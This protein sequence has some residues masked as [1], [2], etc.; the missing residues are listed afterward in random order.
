MYN[1]QIE[2]HNNHLNLIKMSLT[3]VWNNQQSLYTI[4]HQHK[5]YHTC[6][7][8]CTIP[9]CTLTEYNTPPTYKI[10]YMYMYITTIQVQIRNA[11]IYSYSRIIVFHI[12]HYVNFYMF[13]LKS[14]IL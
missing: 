14:S 7:C 5:K 13:T 6:T 8:T 3:L 10:P 11:I 4:Y 1:L 12:I 9:K 2:G